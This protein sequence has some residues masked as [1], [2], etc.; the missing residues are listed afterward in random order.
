MNTSSLQETL[1]GPIKIIYKEYKGNNDKLMEKTY[2]L[3]ELIQKRKYFTN[4]RQVGIFYDDPYKYQ[5]K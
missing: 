2:A 5:E 4:Y 3:E 1:F